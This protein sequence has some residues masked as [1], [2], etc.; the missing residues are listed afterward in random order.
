MRLLLDTHVAIWSVLS[1]GRIPGPVRDIIASS[2]NE[3][4]VSVVVLWEIA[5]KSAIGR[6]ERMPMTAKD[7]RMEFEL[8]QFRLLP[9][10]AEHAIAVGDLP[11]IHGDPFDRLMLAQA[12]VSRL[13]LVTIDGK[14]ADYGD[15]LITW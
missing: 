11:R 2:A 10:L 4:F 5:I 7:A 1:P 14:L 6:G 15:D 9:V 13:R 12:R 3:V 8:A